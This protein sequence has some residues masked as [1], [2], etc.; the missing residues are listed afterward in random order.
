MN[1]SNMNK[2]AYIK[3]TW[4]VV[5]IQH[6]YHILA[7]SDFGGT[8]GNSGMGYGGGSTGDGRVRESDNWDDDLW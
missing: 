6:Q 1:S 5:R 2:K 7:G 8:D 3:P 4:R